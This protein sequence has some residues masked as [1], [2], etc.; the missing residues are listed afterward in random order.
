[1]QSAARTALVAAAIVM[2][3]CDNQDV[4]TGPSSS[5]PSLASSKLVPKEIAAGHA[6]VTAGGTA[7]QYSFTAI[8]DFDGRVKGEWQ[9]KRTLADGA[10][11]RA[12]GEVTCMLMVGN[13]AHMAGMPERSDPA[14]GAPPNNA[15]LWTV[16][17]NDAGTLDGTDV[18]SLMITGVPPQFVLLHCAG[19]FAFGLFPLERGNVLV[20]SI[21]IA[22]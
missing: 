12:H 9:L 6:E 17:D 15:V 22:P 18:A 21:P 10:I 7:D 13:V 14:L 11:Q 20:K 5:G 8:R 16:Q 2:A 19:G 4:P 3:A 1:M